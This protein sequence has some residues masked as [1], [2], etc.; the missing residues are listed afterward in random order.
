MKIPFGGEIEFGFMYYIISAIVLAGMS[1]AVNLSDGVDGLA[2][3]MFIF[4]LIPL[5]ALPVWQNGIIAP[6]CGALAGFLWHNWFP[7]SVFMGDTGALGLGGML[8]TVFVIEGREIFLL[9]FGVMFIIEMFSV[10]LQVGS[11][12]LFGRRIFRM[13]PIHHHFELKGWKE[14]K[15][16]FRFSL[17][18]LTAA[19]VGL[20]AW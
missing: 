20:L 12:K 15:I 9:F 8:A 5:F 14:T 18:A 10:I 11:F 16:A 4:S 1:N 2:G 17:L 19:V 3:S 6:I 7:A 13:S